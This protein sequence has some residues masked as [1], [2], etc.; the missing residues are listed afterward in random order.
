VVK[1][2]DPYPLIRI[3]WSTIPCITA[4]ELND[5]VEVGHD[6]GGRQGQSGGGREEVSDCQRRKDD[7][8]RPMLLNFFDL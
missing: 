1:C 6:V 8:L 4:V 2:T 7:R 5:V 3:S